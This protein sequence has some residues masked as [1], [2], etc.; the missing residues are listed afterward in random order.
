MEVLSS[1]QAQR[2]ER[3]QRFKSQFKGRLLGS[4]GECLHGND[5]LHL[6]ETGL[7]GLPV[8]FLVTPTSPWGGKVGVGIHQP[9]DACGLCV[10]AMSAMVS[11]TKINS[12]LTWPRP[13][14]DADRACE[15]APG[16]SPGQRCFPASGKG[17]SQPLF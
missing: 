3:R 4:R 14:N 1:D 16:S 5:A 9:L 11:D 2:L 6:W 10:S 8:A 7:A 17:T 12:H 15:S 13:E